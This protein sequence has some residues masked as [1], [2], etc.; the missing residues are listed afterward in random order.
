MLLRSQPRELLP[1]LGVLAGYTMLFGLL[2]AAQSARLRRAERVQQ[3]NE[4]FGGKS[5][6]P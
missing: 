1:L 4:I 5:R 6:R 3:W 2:G